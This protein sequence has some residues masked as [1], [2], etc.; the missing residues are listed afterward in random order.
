VS[1]GQR[2]KIVTGSEKPLLA[3]PDEK[4]IEKSIDEEQLND[5][6]KISMLKSVKSVSE[7]S[8]IYTMIT[9]LS[10]VSI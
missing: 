10:L 3:D 5:S 4:T 2:E 7:V 8:M 1:G 6:A 9:P